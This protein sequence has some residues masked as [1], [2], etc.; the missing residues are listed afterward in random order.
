MK[1]DGV[2]DCDATYDGD[3]QS[4]N[5]DDVLVFGSQGSRRLTI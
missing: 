1:L 4:L 5:F 3:R 2:L